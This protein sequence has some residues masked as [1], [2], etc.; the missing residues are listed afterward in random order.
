MVD[1]KSGNAILISGYLGK[2]DVFDEAVSLFAIECAEQNK[3]DY[4]ELVKAA[5]TGKIVAA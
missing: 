1:A 4:E 2:S 3:Q 5:K